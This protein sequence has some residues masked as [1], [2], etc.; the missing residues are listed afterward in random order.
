MG[1]SDAARARKYR[2]RRRGGPPREPEPCPSAAAFKRHVRAGETP[3]DGCKIK[4]A[5]RQHDLYEARK[6]RHAS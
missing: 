6:E 4:E 2:D 1:K 5:E 3:C